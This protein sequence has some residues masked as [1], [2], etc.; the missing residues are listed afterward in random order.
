MAY[1]AFQVR[2]Q[3]VPFTQITEFGP[4]TATNDYQYITIPCYNTVWIQTE[5]C[6]ENNPLEISIGTDA[7]NS[8]LTATSR[9]ASAETCQE[10][11]TLICGV[12]PSTPLSSGSHN[13]LIGY[14]NN[15]PG[16]NGRLYGRIAHHGMRMT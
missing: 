1:L 4:V 13:I 9:V 14:R 10:V 3:V 11:W 8:K 7:T 6:V 15:N 5:F 16:Q 12:P 2:E